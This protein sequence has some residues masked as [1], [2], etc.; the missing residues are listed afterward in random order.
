MVI[1]VNLELSDSWFLHKDVSNELG[2]IS[3]HGWVF[4]QFLVFIVVV[5]IVAYSEELLI[6]V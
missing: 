2:N 3:L 4:I 5:D 6:V 1:P